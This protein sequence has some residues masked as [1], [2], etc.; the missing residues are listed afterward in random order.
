MVPLARVL[1][2]VLELQPNRCVQIV[3]SFRSSVLMG[4]GQF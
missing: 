4:V 1:V 3:L 2:Q